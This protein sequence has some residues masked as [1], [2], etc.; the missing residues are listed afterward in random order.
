MTGQSLLATSGHFLLA[1]HGA[2]ARTSTRS[3]D[4]L[5]TAQRAGESVRLSRLPS[6]T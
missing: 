2:L 1:A 5:K 4:V 3:Q 6:G